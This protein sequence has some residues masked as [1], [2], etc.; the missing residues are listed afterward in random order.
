MNW[1]HPNY[2]RFT[3]ERREYI[4]RFSRPVPSRREKR[5]RPFLPWFKLWALLLLVQ[6]VPMSDMQKFWSAW[7][8]CNDIAAIK[9]GAD[10][11]Q[12]QQVGES[13]A[14]YL[15]VVNGCMVSLGYTPEQVEEIIRNK[16]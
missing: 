15:G 4:G 1:N 12:P 3:S 7:L 14:Q 6:A 13:D 9:E 16:E 8:S 10:S 2:Q 11:S 5:K